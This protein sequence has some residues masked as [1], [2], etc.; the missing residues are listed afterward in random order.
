[1]TKPVHPHLLRHSYATEAVRGGARLHALQAALGH[2]NLATTS[3]YLHTDEAD[4]EA[5]AAV[6]PKVL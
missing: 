4:L 6:T 1:M 2:A 5:V 3:V